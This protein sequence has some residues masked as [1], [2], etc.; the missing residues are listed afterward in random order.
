MKVEYLIEGSDDCPLIR[1]YS[2]TI[3]DCK[4]LL[5]AIEVMIKEN[6]G[7]FVGNLKG[8]KCINN[9]K[10]EFA[11]ANVD[12]GIIQEDTNYFKWSLSINGWFKVKSLLIPFLKEYKN[13]YQWLE[14]TS[15]ISLLI[16]DTGEW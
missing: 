4:R 9:M 12:N 1:I 16:S 13:K 8:Y 15:D 7:F 11:L 10:L 3:D 2:G 14:E 6:K 5:T